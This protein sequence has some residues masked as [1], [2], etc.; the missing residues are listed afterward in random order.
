MRNLLLIL[1]V[2]HG[3]L[4]LTGFAKA[5]KL[6]ALKQL[7]QPISKFNGILWL[8]AGLLFLS[9]ALLFSNYNGSWWI[10]S[11]PAIIISQ[12]LIVNDWRDAGLGTVANIIIMLV[13]VIGYGVW[14]F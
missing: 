10:V 12:Y 5:F 14:S 4:H 3:L 9:A 2:L 11:L 1:I 8:L 13:S 7:T 6:A